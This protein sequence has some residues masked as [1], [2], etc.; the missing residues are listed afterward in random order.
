MNNKK[1]IQTSLSLN[2]LEL[3]PDVIAPYGVHFDK[4]C[5]YNLSK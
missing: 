3:L 4:R 2:N 5:I 1:D